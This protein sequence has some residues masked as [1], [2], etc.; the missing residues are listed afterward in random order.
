ML[1]F[2][3]YLLNAE[4][5][6]TSATR[7]FFAKLD[8]MTFKMVIDGLKGDDYQAVCI[9]IDQLVKEKRPVCIPPLFVVARAHPLPRIREKASEAL[10]TLGQSEEVERLSADKSI[11]DAVKIL[12]EHYGNYKTL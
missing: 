8:Q 4:N 11:Q 6:I 1:D 12:V 10:K 9:V 3:A 5:L 2:Q 7:G